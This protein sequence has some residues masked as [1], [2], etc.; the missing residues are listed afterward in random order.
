VSKELLGKDLPK[1]K[2]NASKCAARSARKS[3][4]SIKK[5]NILGRMSKCRINT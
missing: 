5:E 2:E 4:H 3:H 1:K